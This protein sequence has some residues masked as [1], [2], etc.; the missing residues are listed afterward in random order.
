M[1]GS[2]DKKLRKENQI[3]IREIRKLSYKFIERATLSPLRVRWRLA[4]KILMGKGKDKIQLVLPLS[5]F[6]LLL[7]FIC[8]FAYSMIIGG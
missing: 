6:Q 5:I 3:K 4:L 1:S 2:K 8:V 7:I